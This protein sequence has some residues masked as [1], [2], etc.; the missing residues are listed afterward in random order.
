MV[1]LEIPK[2]IVLDTTVLVN[3]LRST[4]RTGI[5]TRLE[6]KARLATTIINMFELYHG[7]YKSKDVKRNLAA[8]K[9][10]RSTLQVLSLT[11]SSAE[12]A[13]KLLAH[14]ESKGQPLDPRDLFIASICLEHGFAVLTD[15]TEHFRR[16]PELETVPERELSKTL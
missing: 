16:I 9:G 6:E 3:H 10:L 7:A 15:N 12:K 13:G 4:G 5:V 1:P 14:L 2:R 11:E 8:V